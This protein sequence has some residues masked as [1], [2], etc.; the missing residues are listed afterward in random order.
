[1]TKAGKF[2]KINKTTMNNATRIF[3][4]SHAEA[5]YTTQPDLRF[6][7]TGFESSAGFVITD[8]DGT[9]FYTD[10]RYYEAAKAALKGKDISVHLNNERDLE[11][12]LLSR[13]K[14]VAVPLGK[15]L[16]REY[17][18]LSALGL[19]IKDSGAAFCEAMKIKSEAEIET[20]TAACDVTDRAFIALLPKIKEGMTENQVAAEL[21]Y[22]MR[23]FGASGT[24]FDTIVAFGKNSSVPHHE[25]G[26]D[27]LKF[28]DVILIDFGC[29]VGGYCSDCTRTLLFGDDKKHGEFKRTYKEVLNAHMRV[30]E[31][32]KS[33][34]SG[35]IAD[36]YAREYLRGFELDKFFTHTLGH[37]IGVNIHEAPGLSPISEDILVDGMVFSDEPGVYFAG[38]YGVRIEDTVTLRGGRAVSLTDSDKNLIIL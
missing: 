12:K 10:S 7:L 22:L 5:T 34:D 16:Y 35:K 28:G 24:S 37:G 14:E 13:Y 19:R 21:E 38:N 36:G 15:T 31:M 25:T 9:S 26:A 18:K 2:Y 32:L 3:N 11:S 30:K 1:M 20:I 6:Y 4:L 17:E 33:G 23:S 8:K 27:K 29:K